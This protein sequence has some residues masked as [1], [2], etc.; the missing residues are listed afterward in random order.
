M[1]STC[2][3]A[4]LER[5]EITNTQQQ[6]LCGT[7]LPP[8]LMSRARELQHQQED[9][10]FTPISRHYSR[11]ELLEASATGC[12]HF[13]PPSTWLKLATQLL[14]SSE[15]EGADGDTDAKRVTD[16]QGSGAAQQASAGLLPCRLEQRFLTELDEHLQIGPQQHDSQPQQQQ[17]QLQVAH[18]CGRHA[19]PAAAGHILLTGGRGG[20]ITPAEL[21]TGRCARSRAGQQQPAAAVV[22]AHS[23]PAMFSGIS[24]TT[25]RRHQHAVDMADTTLQQHMQDVH[26]HYVQPVDEAGGNLKLPAAVS[27]VSYQHHSLR[28]HSSRAA[29]AHGTAATPQ[30]ALASQLKQVGPPL[31][32]RCCHTGHSSDSIAA[33]ASRRRSSRPAGAQPNRVQQLQAGRQVPAAPAAGFGAPPP[34]A[35]PAGGQVEAAG[36]HVMGVGVHEQLPGEA[37]PP[38]VRV[39]APWRLSAWLLRSDARGRP[40]RL[41][42]RARA[43]RLSSES[44]GEGSS[45]DSSSGDSYSGSSGGAGCHNSRSSGGLGSSSNR[46]VTGSPSRCD[47]VCYRICIQSIQA[48]IKQE[49][50][51]T[52]EGVCIGSIQCVMHMWQ[53]CLRGPLLVL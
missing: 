12:N 39:L 49:P 33:S 20:P 21:L 34:P 43:V 24:S 18:G 41:V 16:Q 8:S 13:S 46:A 25:S 32:G 26:L 48:R 52:A 6:L 45:S 10:A 36:P 28:R 4:S 29:T 27:A 30:A 17:Q 47:K 53:R 23:H 31:A 11:Q 3:H 15:D 9:A 50:I 14:S 19:L 42:Q 51:S 37:T 1:A 2:S 44:E 40:Q 22:A 38:L 35:A 5:R 7:A